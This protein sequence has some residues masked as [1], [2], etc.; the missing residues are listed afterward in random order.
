MFILIQI[1]FTTKLCLWEYT[2][3]YNF[4]DMATKVKVWRYLMPF[5]YLQVEKAARNPDDK[6]NCASDVLELQAVICKWIQLSDR[7]HNKQTLIWPPLL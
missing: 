7:Y 1:F 2:D 4:R 6:K 3:H 5:S